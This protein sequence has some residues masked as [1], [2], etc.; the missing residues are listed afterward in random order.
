MQTAM[1]HPEYMHH[2]RSQLA[3]FW[4]AHRK[5][6]DQNEVMLELL[7]GPNPITDDELRRLIQRDPAR[8]G[9]FSGYLGTRAS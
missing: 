6:A 9:R 7:F 1:P 2:P 3:A 8:Y 5:I 4:R